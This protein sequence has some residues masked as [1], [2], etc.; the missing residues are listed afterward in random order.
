VI[1]WSLAT[2]ALGSAAVI[3]MRGLVAD[4]G[5]ASMRAKQWWPPRTAVEV[6]TTAGERPEHE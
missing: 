2:V 4:A 1:A 6:F 3:G 5:A